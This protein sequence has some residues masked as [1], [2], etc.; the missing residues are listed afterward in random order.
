MLFSNGSPPPTNLHRHLSTNPPPETRAVRGGPP[1]PLPVWS[2]HPL[3][4]RT[5]T[6]IQ[7]PFDII[8]WPL[9]ECRRLQ[10]PCRVPFRRNALPL[11]TINHTT[12]HNAPI[13][14]KQAR[15]AGSSLPLSSEYT[16]TARRRPDEPPPPSPTQKP[17]LAPPT[18]KTAPATAER[19]KLPALSH[20]LY[21]FFAFWIFL[22]I[23][24]PLFAPESCKG[25]GGA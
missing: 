14:I 11:F 20:M 4:T 22:F 13:R 12:S 21:L 9:L 5:N 19:A 3:L 6:H 15:C 1:Y 18:I 24:T 2:G 17:R 8:I 10:K 25:K 7:T 23:I 16:H